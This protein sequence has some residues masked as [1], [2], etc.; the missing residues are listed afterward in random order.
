MVTEAVLLNGSYNYLGGSD[1]G[2][3]GSSLSNHWKTTGI[4]PL[5]KSP[6]QKG[7]DHY[8]PKALLK[9]FSAWF[10]LKYLGI[11]SYI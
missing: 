8:L 4:S 9:E 5:T 6:L 2:H 3:W 1:A 11:F 7:W 10:N